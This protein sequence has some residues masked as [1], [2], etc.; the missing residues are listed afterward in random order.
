[1]C[2]HM[3]DTSHGHAGKLTKLTKMPPRP[4]MT[5]DAATSKDEEATLFAPSSDTNKGAKADDGLVVN[6]IQALCAHA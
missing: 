2:A 3:A 4:L 1:M 5:L 6:V